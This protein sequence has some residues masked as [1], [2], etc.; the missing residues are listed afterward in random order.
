MVE[1][2]G[3]GEGRGRA[4]VPV[5]FREQYATSTLF[6]K[7][8]REGMALVEETAG[9]LDGPGRQ[10]S[11]MLDRPASLAYAT[12]SMRLTTRLM[13]MASWLLLQRAVKDGELTSTE[14]MKEKYQVELDDAGSDNRTPGGSQLPAGLRDLIVR[15]LQLHDRILRL[16]EM[17]RTAAG[18]GSD[19]A[20][21][22]DE[23]FDRIRA[24][25]GAKNTRT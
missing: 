6:D 17:L 12:E 10:A 18:S 14:A 16:D 23:Q 3:S 22:L 11:K 19:R 7:T 25:F 21:A 13:Q 9:Y 2:S 15:S 1:S 4:E 20:Q 8:F 24:A 5:D